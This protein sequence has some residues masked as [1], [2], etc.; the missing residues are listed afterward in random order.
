VTETNGLIM[1]LIIIAV[2]FENDLK[3]SVCRMQN[4]FNVK[5]ARTLTTV[6]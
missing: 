3:K 5:S 2:Y 1:L 4:Y 6:L